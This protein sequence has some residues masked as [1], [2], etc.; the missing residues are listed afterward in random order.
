MEVRMRKLLVAALLVGTGLSLSGCVVAPAPRAY[1]YYA[2]G[3]GYYA[4]P[5][6]R[7]Y[8]YRPRGYYY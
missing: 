7:P 6:Y 1:G 2:P 4:A 5:A 3:P 8:Y